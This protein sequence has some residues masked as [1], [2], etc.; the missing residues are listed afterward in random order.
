MSRQCLSRR[1]DT[2]EK[3]TRELG[4]WQVE[5]NQN[6]KTVKWQFN[7]DDARIKLHGLYP[8]I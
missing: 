8:V 2:L 1:I 5:R 3:L 7:S 4:A 6:R